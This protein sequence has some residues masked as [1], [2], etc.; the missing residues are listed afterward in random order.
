MDSNNN[1]IVKNNAIRK[2]ENQVKRVVNPEKT[3][4]AKKIIHNL[5][6]YHI[7]SLIS[8]HI[9]E[10]LIDFPDELPP[11]LC[12]NN[13]LRRSRSQSQEVKVKREKTFEEETKEFI[14][15]ENIVNRRRSRFSGTYN[16]ADLEK[17]SI[18]VKEE[19]ALKK[20]KSSAGGECSSHPELKMKI[21]GLGT[22][23]KITREA[24][25]DESSEQASDQFPITG[26]DKL[27]RY[28]IA[29]SQASAV[30]KYPIGIIAQM[31]M[32]EVKIS[33]PP[34]KKSKLDR[35]YCESLLPS[36]SKIARANLS[37][38]LSAAEVNQSN[39]RNKKRSKKKTKRI[40]T[41]QSSSEDVLSS[42]EP[43]LIKKK[44]PKMPSSSSSDVDFPMKP[45][46][47]TKVPP[48]M[49][50]AKT[51]KPVNNETKIL[52]FASSCDFEIRVNNCNDA[53]VSLK[54]INASQNQHSPVKE[55]P[56]S[57][58]NCSKPPKKGVEKIKFERPQ[59]NTEEKRDKKLNSD[60][61]PIEKK[62]S[63]EYKIPPIIEPPKV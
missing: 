5:T 20:E 10:A 23:S 35:D 19:P 8:Q 51:P 47:C 59:Q 36:T 37:S 15:D 21:T 16:L 24:S 17:A 33:G 9:P 55:Y 38:Q 34:E 40:I 3:K 56:S 29:I 2:S 7:G 30:P 1:H 4:I 26:S 28:H 43:G 41:P 53:T 18:T 12:Y 52:P 22:T 60:A 54:S 14:G 49:I 45:S 48:I 39:K 44:P 58:R 62:I 42:D 61:K 63:K 46:T 31:Q 32:S 27:K 11:S 25:E 57:Q 50:S 13:F 6:L